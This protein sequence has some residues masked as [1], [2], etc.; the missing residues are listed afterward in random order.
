MVKK[1]KDSGL[2]GN[3][4]DTL[5]LGIGSMAGHYAI[6]SMASMP[7]MPV[8][9]KQT[10]NIAGSGLTL[11]NVGQLGKTGLGIANMMGNSLSSKRVVT[12][13]KKCTRVQNILNKF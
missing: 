8:A 6:G 9:A 4:K 5:K 7:G 11:L 13:N 10:A 2:M 12:K 3:M 1:N